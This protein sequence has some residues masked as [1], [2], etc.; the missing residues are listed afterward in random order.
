MKF[1]RDRDYFFGLPPV[2]QGVWLKALIVK[3]IR[4]LL[5]RVACCWRSFL[6]SLG[7]S[8][9][10]G[11]LQ[12]TTLFIES[13]SRLLE[14]D[15]HLPPTAALSKQSTIVQK[16]SRKQLYVETYS[17][18][19]AQLSATSQKACHSDILSNGLR[20]RTCAHR[21]LLNLGFCFFGGLLLMSIPIS[22]HAASDPLIGYWK[23]D[24]GAGT[25]ATD[26]SNYG[27]DGT[28]TNMDAGTDWISGNGPS[29]SFTN[30]YAL[31]FDGVD[32]YVDVPS[33][34]GWEATTWAAWVRLDTNS[35]RPAIMAGTSSQELVFGHLNQEP[36]LYWGGGKY[37]ASGTA[38][39]LGAWHHI[40]FT[41]TAGDVLTLYVDGVD[42]GSVSG[43]V[44]APMQS[45]E[46]GR[47]TPGYGYIDGM[48]DDA[49]VY[50][51]A[52]SSSEMSEL[53]AGTH[54]SATWDGSSDTDWYTAANW[55]INAV[56]D[57]HTNVIIA[58]TA[59][60]P[61]IATD[62]SS[63][64]LIGHWKFDEGTGTSAADSSGNG[65]TGTLTNMESGDWD[66]SEKPS[67][68]FTNPYSL[69]FSGT[70]EYVTIASGGPLD[71]LQTGTISMWVRWSGTQDAAYNN[72]GQ[73]FSRAKSGSYNTFLVGLTTNDPDTAIIEWDP[74]QHSFAGAAST[75]SPGD[76]TWRHLAIAFASGNHKLYLDGNLE[77]TGTLT[78][79]M[80]TDTEEMTIGASRG[81]MEGYSTSKI[82]DVRV[83][84]AFL[85]SEDISALSSG[86]NQFVVDFVD[87]TINSSASLDVGA[88]NLTINDSGA[89]SNS[90]TFTLDGDN[91]FTS[92]TADTDSGTIEYGGTG[93]YS[94]GLIL[95]DT[96]NN[97][98]F[99]GSGGSWVLDAALDVNNDLTLADGT[100]DVKSG[101]DYAV[102][103]GG[104][105]INNGGT[106]T[107]RS[108]TVTLDGTSQTIGG[109]VGTTFY[110]LIKSVLSA[111]TLTF[112]NA[113]TTTIDNNTTLT[114]ADGDVLSLRS[115]L[116][117]TQFEIDISNSGTRTLQHIDVKDSNN[118]NAT[119]I[120]CSSG[121]INSDNNTNWSFPITG[122]VYT[123]EGSTNIGASKT[124]A[125]SINGGSATTGETSA[126]GSYNISLGTMPSSGDVVTVYLDD[127]SGDQAV[128]VFV[129]DGINHGDHDLYED[130]LIVKD[131]E[132]STITT[133]NLATA[134]GN[135]DSDITDF[136][137]VSGSDLAVSDTKELLI[138]TGDTYA[139]GG[140]VT[141]DDIDINGTFTMGSNAITISGSWD[142]TGGT[143]TSSG[144]VTLDSTTTETITSNSNSFN[145]L[146]LNGSSGHWNLQDAIDVDGVLTISNGTLD[147]NSYSLT[148]TGGSFTN[149]D[150]LRMQGS[151]TLTG[152]TND[153][154]SG[155]TYFDGTGTYTSLSPSM[156]LPL[157]PQAP[158]H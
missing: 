132:G 71:N 107:G 65:Y 90:G 133:A 73:V 101:S 85:S 11:R 96:Y 34:P 125:V 17:N 4:T 100:L 158:G 156:T 113:I 138:W 91:T 89:F 78:G 114:G 28:L 87:L 121:C 104:D 74:Y 128:L 146:T 5:N 144:T 33:L 42:T 43:A 53:A 60:D 147:L 127:E 40:G 94:S 123:D 26:S 77:G 92:F 56:P 105:W 80:Q 140:A 8:V 99:N 82:D 16:E 103:V 72:Y 110:N 55:D 58:D 95:G 14:S 145:N 122:T 6:F 135:G 41:L 112:N 88:T 54:T 157:T 109:S 18:W 67:V 124:V 52:L 44:A 45:I 84:N 79:T 31:D 137:S 150:T 134:D 21:Y 19:F 118:T 102:T 151:E 106:F 130:R 50:N 62:D 75:T 117:D 97:L 13:F 126:A 3:K 36:E 111:D 22:T 7:H 120:I 12:T 142:A 69:N 10:K 93:T 2:S 154:N 51:R 57:S 25:T 136:Y 115:D 24:D 39:T 131:D 15:A 29:L 149:N 61:V 152:F 63:S 66:A 143:F 86:G 27:S 46:I 23:F 108:G 153:T 139:P 81:G 32:D 83:Y 20:A 35:S 141:A 129:S 98:S 38:V 48:I 49:R 70:D 37:I 64:S 76:G 59:N 9:K 116:A 155:T 30:T 148:N 1:L 47:R 68:S 119:E